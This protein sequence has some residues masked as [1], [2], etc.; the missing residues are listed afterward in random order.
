MATHRLKILHVARHATNLVGQFNQMELENKCAESLGLPWISKIYARE[1]IYKTG[2]I[3]YEPMSRHFRPGWLWAAFQPIRL[4]FGFYFWLLRE[5]RKYDIVLLRYS[6]SDPLLT[7]FLILKGR[8]TLL[9]HHTKE[10]PEL[11]LSHGF[12]G[13]FRRILEKSAGT[14]SISLAAGL[15]GVTSEIIRYERSR[16]LRKHKFEAVYPNGCN[17]DSII[18]PKNLTAFPTMIFL[19]SHFLPWQGLEILL[20]SAALE[21]DYFEIHIIGETSSSLKQMISSDRRFKCHGV[22]APSE[23]APLVAKA[24]LGISALALDRKNMEE[25]CALKVRDYLSWGLPSAGAYRETLPPDFP[26]WFKVDPD[27]RDLLKI[28]Y[29]SRFFERH[30]V[31]EASRPFIAKEALMASL[32]NALTESFG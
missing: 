12:F 4:R 18:Q 29:E 28:A 14:V 22:L 10:L 13:N 23:I 24:W 25:A 11:S 19:A 3:V 9:V 27:I 2:D 31:V 30:E 20:K 16:S 17:L 26:F 5:Q 21:D 15:V 8:K 32:H 6:P 1:G 7:I